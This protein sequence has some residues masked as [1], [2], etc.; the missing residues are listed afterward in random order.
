MELDIKLI[1]TEWIPMNLIDPN[2]GQIP[3]VK[4][5]PRRI[6]KERFDDLVKSI[7]EDPEML[8]LNPVWVFP[9]EGRYVSLSGNQRY[10][11]LKA[12][13]IKKAPCKVIPAD[14]PAETLNRYIVKINAHYGEWDWDMLGNEWEAPELNSWGVNVSQDW[15]NTD[16]EFAGGKDHEGKET[17]KLSDLKYDPLYY[18]PKNKPD[19]HLEDCL[20][21]EKFNAK[22]AALD[23]YDLTKKQ[24]D[25]LRFF[26]YRFIKIDFEAVA[27]YYAFNA[28]EAEKSAIERLRLV[29]VDGGGR[30]D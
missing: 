17:A 3:G 23:E 7:E 13:K 4:A 26:A 16:D 1:Q 14:T 9:Y 20:N 6:K 18:D 28:T 24:K 10:E 21:L 8:A 30:T 2:K 29:L 25:L 27:N 12:K 5:N 22:I 15:T 11:A 19:L